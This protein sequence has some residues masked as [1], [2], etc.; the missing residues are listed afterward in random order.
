[1]FFLVG[2]KESQKMHDIL[3]LDRFPIDQPD[4]PEYA[5]LVAQCQMALVKDGMYNLVG[6]L[7]LEHAQSAADAL[8][9][10]IASKS[11]THNRQHNIYFNKELAYLPADH[12]AL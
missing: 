2:K 12:P 8:K 1:M 5:A 3:D 7:R 4:T 11:F 9:P 10:K 6:F